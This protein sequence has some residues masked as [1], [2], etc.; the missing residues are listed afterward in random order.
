[1]GFGGVQVR[2]P[3]EVTVMPSGP[4]V[5]EK[6]RVWA[7]RSTSEA[8]RVRERVCPSA[9]AW[10]GMVAMVGAAL[11]SETVTEKEREAAVTPSETVISTIEVPGPWASVG[12]QVRRPAEVT[13]MP[14]GPE[15]R[16]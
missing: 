1:M 12:V 8:E 3:A 15:V 4:E 5:R 16:E 6:V 7:G 2:R 9:T 14:S 10:S 13:V 11:T